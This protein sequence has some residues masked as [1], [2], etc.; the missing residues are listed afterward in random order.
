MKKL[1]GLGLTTIGAAF[2]LTSCGNDN[3]STTTDKQ[4]TSADQ[5]STAKNNADTMSHGKSMNMSSSMMSSMNSS[6]E[7]LKNMSM[8]GDFDVDFAN[9]MVEHHQ[10]ALEMAQVEL[11]QGKDE[12]LK[13]KAQEIITKQKKEQQELRDFISGYKPSSM[14]HGEGE[15]QKSMSAS[16]DKMKGMQ[17]SGDVD[18]DFT[19]M[20]TRH[21]EDGISMAKMELKNGM[22]DKLK[23]MAQKI[24]ND[25]QKDIAEFK[26]WMSSHK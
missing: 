26:S 5:T 10:S 13:A 20:M 18:K 23:Q 3:T 15:L 22:S 24:I 16:M 8:T 2:L 7:K 14:K 17:M 9:M 6:M 12:T 11:S 4:D 1:I 25:Q 19:M 21:H